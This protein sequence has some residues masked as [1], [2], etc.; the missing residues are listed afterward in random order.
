MWQSNFFLITILF[1]IIKEGLDERGSTLKS[2]LLI[3][4][5]VLSHEVQETSC[6]RVGVTG[7]DFWAV[8]HVEPNLDKVLAA[9]FK[10]VV[11][12]VVNNGQVVDVAAISGDVPVLVSYIFFLKLSNKLLYTQ[13]DYRLTKMI[14][15]LHA[16]FLAEMT[17]KF[18]FVEVRTPIAGDLGTS[19]VWSL[20]FFISS[21]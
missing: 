10:I 4:D 12:Q 2:A 21:A 7:W 11:L 3:Y 6:I 5:Y 8:T 15:S 1:A 13:T 9:F 14:T 20:T 18:E 16:W 17:L 19:I